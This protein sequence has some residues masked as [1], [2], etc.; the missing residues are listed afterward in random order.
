[1]VDEAVDSDF[2]R[3]RVEVGNRPM[4]AVVAFGCNEAAPCINMISRDLENL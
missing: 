2:V 3:R 1:M 4:V